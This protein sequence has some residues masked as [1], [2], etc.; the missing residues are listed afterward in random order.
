[1]HIEKLRELK[2]IGIHIA[3]DDFGSGYSSLN[4]LRRL[5]LNVLKI[6][7]SF[8]DFIHTDTE[9]EGLVATIIDIAGNMGLEVIAEGVELQEQRDLLVSRGCSW[10]Q[11]YLVAKP[12]PAAQIETFLQEHNKAP[13]ADK[14]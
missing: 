1:M 10:M 11:G 2:K 5:P 4:Y 7:K 9:S 6:D 14:E 3:L 8:I 12:L 13:G